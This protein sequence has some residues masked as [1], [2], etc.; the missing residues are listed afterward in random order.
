MSR[1]GTKGSDTSLILACF[2][3]GGDGCY[4]AFFEVG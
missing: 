1:V 4:L 2:G 3:V